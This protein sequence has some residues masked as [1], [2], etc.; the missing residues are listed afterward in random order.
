[1]ALT[2]LVGMLLVITVDRITHPLIEQQQRME[3]QHAS[4]MNCSLKPTRTHSTISTA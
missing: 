2:G 1:M 3:H 4:C